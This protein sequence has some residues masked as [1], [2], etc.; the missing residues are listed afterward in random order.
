MTGQGGIVTYGAVDQDKKRKPDEKIG[1]NRGMEES[2]SEWTKKKEKKCNKDPASSEKRK[3]ERKKKTKETKRKKKDGKEI[4]KG[5][6]TPPAL[7]NKNKKKKKFSIKE[8]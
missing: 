6:S 7:E 4:Y 3:E 1:K 8:I 5:R 2:R